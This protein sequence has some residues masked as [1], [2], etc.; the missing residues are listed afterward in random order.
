MNEEMR[1]QL[2][3]YKNKYEN[4]S[5]DRMSHYMEVALE[6]CRNQNEILKKNQS[7]LEKSL[8]GEVYNK[9]SLE[10]RNQELKR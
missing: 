9:N 8:V 1:E 6:S 10:D 4:D 2:F 3:A 7:E 5:S